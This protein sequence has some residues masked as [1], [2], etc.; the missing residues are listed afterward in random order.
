[1]T[2]TRSITV[3]NIG[4]AGS[5]L[6]VT[7]VSISTGY[8]VITGLPVSGLASGASRSFTVQCSPGSTSAGT[9][10]VATNETGSPQ[11]TWTLS[12]SDLAATSPVFSSDPVAG[13]SGRFRTILVTNTGPAGT[14]LDVE[15]IS[16]TPAFVISGLPIAGLASGASAEVTI[17]FSGAL[18]G[19]DSLV[20][21]TNEPGSPTYAWVIAAATVDVPALDPRMLALLAAILAVTG[22]FLTRRTS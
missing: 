3:S 14:F 4:G 7:Q 8:A 5:L 21:R 11:Y 2:A 17:A 1:M 13:S 22:V 6:N 9:L 12:C 18:T 10:V 15:Q 20:V 19:S 16:F